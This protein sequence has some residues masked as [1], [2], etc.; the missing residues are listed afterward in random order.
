MEFGRGLEVLILPDGQIGIAG[1]EQIVEVE[2]E[3][4]TGFISGCER[5]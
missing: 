2:N 5:D 3:A 1:V 4:Q